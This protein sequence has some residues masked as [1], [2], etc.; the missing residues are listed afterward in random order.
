LSLLESFNKETQFVVWN[1]ILS[2][3]NALRNTWLFEDEAVKDALKSF[4]LTL[5]SAKAHELGWEFK[6]DEDHIM[7]QFKSLMFGS[8]GLAGDAK[9]QAAAREMF[10][11][12]KKGDHSAVHPNLRSSVFAMCVRD[13]D[14]SDWQALLD[15]FH[16]APTADE[17]NT[18][19]RTL[20][21]AKSE[22]LIKKTLALALG[23]EVKMQDIYMPIGGLSTTSKGVE[24]RWAW[25]KE[26][27]SELVE[28][29]PPSMSMLSS[30]VSICTAPFTKEE[31]LKEVQGFFKDVDKKGFDRSLEQSFDSVRSKMGWLARDKGDVEGWLGEKGYLGKGKL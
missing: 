19:L 25:M 20:G 2:R 23:G 30:V 4:Q 14:E 1:E 17:R 28:R 8:A 15:R 21:R 31:Q 3:I 6:E 7:S 12:F 27:W 10:D 11:K 24:M 9:I 16:S 18:C 26:N 22:H 13:G 5:C 29:L